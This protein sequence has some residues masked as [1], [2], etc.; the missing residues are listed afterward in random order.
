MLNDS[1]RLVTCVPFATDSDGDVLLRVKIERRNFI[2]RLMYPEERKIQLDRLGSRVWI[3]IQEGLTY[4]QIRTAI[5][6]EFPHEPDLEKRFETFVIHL[7]RSNWAKPH[8]E[9]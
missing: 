4:L 5:K 1:L 3:K 7:C 9:T 2:A 6:R 8:E